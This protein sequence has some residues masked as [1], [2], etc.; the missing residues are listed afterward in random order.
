MNAIHLI[1]PL[2]FAA[3]ADGGLPSRFE[4]IAYSGGPIPNWDGQTLIDLSSTRVES[5]MPLLLHHAPE[6][7]IGVV[8]V[9]FNDGQAIRV[10]GTLFSDIDA[11]ARDIAI[12]SARGAPYQMSVG[13]YDASAESV[14]PGATLTLNGQPFTGP[15]TVL[16]NGHVREVS[17]VPL[18][19]DRNTAATF[20]SA[21][22]EITPMPVEPT[23]APT[24][25]AS[26]S[27]ELDAIKVQLSE[28][29]ARAERAEA[30]IAERDQADRRRDVEALF[31]GIGRECP[32]ERMAVYLSMDPDTF[33][34]VAADLKASKPQ[35][36]AHLFKEQAVGEPIAPAP[37]PLSRSE[38]YAARRA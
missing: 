17:V 13:L 35:A 25:E 11:G 32:A 9:S 22:P 5:G 6:H 12:K 8:E 33:S 16:R 1:A 31:S 24:V 34:A 15:L 20:F 26:A 2:T 14:P 21:N 19:A 37:L 29:L 38:I 3:E 7:Y 27:A 23:A 36:P 30:V 10:S 4:G 28:A 18:G